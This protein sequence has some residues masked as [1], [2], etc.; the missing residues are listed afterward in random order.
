MRAL[1]PLL[2]GG[3]V[4]LAGCAAPASSPTSTGPRVRCLDEPRY[5]QTLDATRPIFFLFCVQSP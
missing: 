3:L 2:L 4:A 1:L 5:G